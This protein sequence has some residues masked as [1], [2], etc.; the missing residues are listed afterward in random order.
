MA[1]MKFDIE[2]LVI[3]PVRIVEVKWH[4]N[5][6][7]RE[8]RRGIEAAFNMTNDVFEA[9]LAVCSRRRIVNVDSRDMRQVVVRL[10]VKKLC[11]LGAELLHLIILS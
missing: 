8:N 2:K 5:E 1:H 7:A 6:P 11:I 10:H 3:G 9:N 4:V